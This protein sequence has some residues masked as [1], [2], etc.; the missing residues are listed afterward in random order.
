MQP[1]VM[2]TCQSQPFSTVSLIYRE[3]LALRKGGADVA[4]RD[5][6]GKTALELAMERRGAPARPGGSSGGAQGR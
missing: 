1:V 3:P 6:Q 2:A 4:L 5:K